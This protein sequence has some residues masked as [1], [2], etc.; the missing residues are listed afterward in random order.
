[1]CRSYVKSCSIV[2]IYDK[3]CK[4]KWWYIVVFCTVIFIRYS[5]VF[6]IYSRNVGVLLFLALLACISEPFLYKLQSVV[7][8]RCNSV[9]C[10]CGL[11]CQI[12]KCAKGD[13]ENFVTGNFCDWDFSWLGDY[14]TYFVF[15][16]K[17]S[18]ALGIKLC[19]KNIRYNATHFNHHF[20]LTNLNV[21]LILKGGQ[22]C[23]NRLVIDFFFGFCRQKCNGL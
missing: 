16:L 18:M 12:V 5:K 9:L 22:C 3:N 19:D 13:W 10:F 11:C 17:N 8:T 23:F 7:F 1:M 21:D 2:E 6:T 4:I 15:N 14:V 20:L